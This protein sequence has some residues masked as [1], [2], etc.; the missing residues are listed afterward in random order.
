MVAS[1]RMDITHTH[2]PERKTTPHAEAQGCFCVRLLEHTYYSTNLEYTMCD[3]NMYMHHS[4]YHHFFAL[5]IPSTKKKS[6]SLCVFRK[7]SHSKMI[8]TSVVYYARLN[9]HTKWNI[10]L[11]TWALYYNKLDKSPRNHIISINGSDTKQLTN[12]IY[13][14]PGNELL[15]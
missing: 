12:E 7:I 1:R 10:F 14:M 8:R 11:L 3:N 9:T 6:I 4:M 2:T 13:K 5:T 15:G